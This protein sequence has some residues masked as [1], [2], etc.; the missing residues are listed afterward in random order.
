[1]PVLKKV[2]PTK[3][4]VIPE[5]VPE[6]EPAESAVLDVNCFILQNGRPPLLGKDPIAPWK[7]RAWMLPMVQ[8]CHYHPQV[9]NRWDYYLRTWM[10][11]KLLD[12]PIPQMQFGEGNPR[13]G[14]GMKMIEKA[15]DIMFHD[16]GSWSA[17]PALIEWL[18]WA[19]GLHGVEEPRLQEKTNEALYRHFNLGPLL[20][21]PY[22]YLGT[23]YAEGKGKWNH[24][25]FYPT[26]HNVVEM[27]ARMQCH[28]LVEGGL[29]DGRD[30]RTATICD[31]CVGSGRMLLHASN[32]SLCLY[33]MDIDRLCVLMT[34]INGVLYAPWLTFPFPAEI[35]GERIVTGSVDEGN[36][37]VA[38]TEPVYTTQEPEP[39]Y[40]KRG[41][42]LL[43]AK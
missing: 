7:Y 18:A 43:F 17:F 28:D 13:I 31:P 35:T 34:K 5:P 23:L 30:P 39:L 16:T 12:E 38:G 6:P 26:P 8:Q 24:T 25:G 20:L 29:P 40:T 27:M 9:V 22:D 4:K 3:A 11:G 15:L 10:G 2:K 36:S 14:E 37:L 21:Q 41:Q 19:M 42:G 33:G 32:Y 1:M